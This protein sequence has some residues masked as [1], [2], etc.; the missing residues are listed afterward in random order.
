[1]H[2]QRQAFWIDL[3]LFVLVLLVFARS[4]G[5][6]FLSTWD[7]KMYVLGNPPVNSGLSWPNLRWAFAEFHAAN[8]HP[9]TWISLQLDASIFGIRAWGFHLTNVLLHGISVI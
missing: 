8:W 6:D 3:G 5:N 9:L 1:M 7:D 2:N 4:C